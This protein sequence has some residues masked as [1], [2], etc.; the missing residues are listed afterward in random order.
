MKKSLLALAVLGAFAGAA[1]AQ[2]NVTVYGVADVGITRLS[3]NAVEAVLG[4]SPRWGLDS[5]SDANGSRLGFK[6]SEDLG[7]G[8][9]A[10]F[11]LESGFNLDNGTL[12]QGTNQLFGRQAWVGLNGGFGAV[13]L[14]HQQTP[15]YNVVESIDPFNAR[16]AGSMIGVFAVPVRMSNTV[17]Y[18]L[19]KNLGGFYGE[20]AYGFGEVAGN[21]SANRQIGLSA[22]YA[23]GPLNVAL[24]NH[25]VNVQAA[26]VDK[27]NSIFV[28]ATYDFRVVKA[29]AA[30]A[31]D[32]V[33]IMGGGDVKT[34]D[35]MLGV[36]APVGAGTVMAS[37]QRSD[38]KDV[39]A[40][41]DQ[42]ALGY[43]H[44]LSKRTSLYTSYGHVKAEAAGADAT[45]NEF[46]VGIRHAF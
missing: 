16:M 9:S 8:L 4:G 41:I 21:T 3:G 35:Y 40:K 17:N 2:S 38:V 24:A 26:G 5:T 36:S 14:G 46:N 22:G 31:Q 1:S 12:A 42:W 20:V 25:N 33:E 29:H 7:G 32:K 39:D 34:N 44:N 18:S 30:Y 19:P 45:A 10:I 37:F 13:K 6:G 43:S 27:T 11:T 15:Y 28:G 23:N